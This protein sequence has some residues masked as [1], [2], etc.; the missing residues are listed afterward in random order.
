MLF[1]YIMIFSLMLNSKVVLPANYFEQKIES[2]RNTI[3][4][5]EVV[6]KDMIP[7]GCSYG[8]YNEAGKLLYGNFD[9]KASQDVWAALQSNENSAGRNHYYKVFRRDKQ[10]CI[11][12]YSLMTQFSNPLFRK[13]L[14]SPEWL[15]VILFIFFFVGEVVLLSTRFG[16]YL[17]KE[18]KLLMHITQKIKNQDLDFQTGHSAISEIEEVIESLNQMKSALKYSLEKQWDMEK[19][20][21]SQISALAHDIKTP[22]TIIKG[23]AEL[24][25]ETCQDAEQIKYNSYILK[26]AEEIEHY[27]KVLMDMTK[28][29]DIL[30]LKPVRI[31]TKAFFQKLV[32]QEKALS[33][34]KNL[35]LI[36][37]QGA[38]PKFFYGD[39]ELLY[40]AITNVIANAVEYS[41]K[42]GSI[43]FRVQGNENNLQFLI[44][45]SGN[46]FS[47]EELES[48]TEQF[49]RGDKSRNSKNHYGIG[50]SITKSF[51]KLHH[52]DIELSNS[53][54]LGGAQ[55]VLKISLDA[56]I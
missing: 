7:E 29:E 31:E 9:S 27:L 47:K 36:N 50:L 49:Y 3:L 21:K 40:R 8:V 37:E 4:K 55:V 15:M 12:E 22:L 24:I 26:S 10:I 34:E 33:S 6:T 52:G 30:V 41:S 16:R 56:T 20:R 2:N 51:V 18:M 42:N 38:I 53:T 35:Q 28:S 5:A 39:E 32:E 23:N 25:K 13:Y 17:S 44:A 19:S 11:V 14:G 43:L 48:A 45:D 54:K 46:G 1:V